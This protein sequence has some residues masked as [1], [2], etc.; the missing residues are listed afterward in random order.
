MLVTT[1]KYFVCT[2]KKLD[3]D[4]IINN[5]IQKDNVVVELKQEIRKTILNSYPIITH[6]KNWKL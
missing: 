6:K 5:Q 2:A 3:S 1:G 4:F